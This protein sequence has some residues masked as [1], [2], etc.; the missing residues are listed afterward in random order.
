VVRGLSVVTSEAQ[1]GL[2]RLYAT[3]LVAGGAA[4]VVFFIGKANL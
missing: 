1:N 3:V 2:V 4:L